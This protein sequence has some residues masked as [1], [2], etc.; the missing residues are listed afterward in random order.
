VVA[1]GSDDERDRVPP[2]HPA[3]SQELLKS[4]L[5]RVPAGAVS[6]DVS[7][8]ME[9]WV[10]RLEHATEAGLDP[11]MSHIFS[12]GGEA[13]SPIHGH[14]TTRAPL[15]PAAQKPRDTDALDSPA[16]R[17]AQQLEGKRSTAAL[18]TEEQAE[19]QE[20]E[21]QEQEQ[22]QEQQQEQE[23]RCQT[24]AAGVP[25]VGGESRGGRWADPEA[26]LAGGAT[27]PRRLSPEELQRR[28]HAE[29]AH[30]EEV[31]A[32]ELELASLEHARE[33]AAAQ[34]EMVGA[35]PMHLKDPFQTP[36]EF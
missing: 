9:S 10:K 29:L 30:L 11:R 6:I 15:Q 12:P 26:P 27:A 31:E 19:E 7:G 3:L 23:A 35:P 32:V 1:S 28:L 18:P 20:Q 36:V 17:D 13:L 14:P 25:W 34:H 33:L 4:S 2:L 8:S 5:R 24:D 16:T 22:Q 21:E